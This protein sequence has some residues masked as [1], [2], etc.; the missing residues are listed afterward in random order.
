MRQL[1]AIGVRLIA[2]IHL[3]LAC[4]HSWFCGSFSLPSKWGRMGVIVPWYNHLSQS[5]GF[6]VTIYFTTCGCK[7]YLLSLERQQPQIPLCLQGSSHGNFYCSFLSSLLLCNLKFKNYQK[8]CFIW[9][10]ISFCQS[11]E[12]S[13]QNQ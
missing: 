1:E 3:H 13:H 2:S 5:L 10:V 11:L 9:G 6:C 12:T 8:R 4:K 7:C